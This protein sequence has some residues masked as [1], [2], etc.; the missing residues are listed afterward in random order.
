MAVPDT[1]AHR[2]DVCAVVV[3]Y[4]PDDEFG[5]RVR[6]V[7]AQVAAT[8]IVDNG[9]SAA[10][11]ER[12]RELAASPEVTWIHNSENLGIA[13]ALNQGLQHALGLGFAWALL[14]DQDTLVDDTL[15]ETLRA[16]YAACP[17]PQR[18][19][20]VGARYRDTHDRPDDRR[21]LDAHGETW[22]EV[23]AVITSGTLL[24][25]A[26][27]VAIGPFRDEFFID[28]VDI[29]YCLRARA[30]GYRII[31]TR[32]PL[33]SHTVGAPS[34][35]QM[36]GKSKWTTNHPAERRYYIA[37]NNTVLLREYGSSKGGSWRWKS[38]VRSVRLCK[39][40]A[41]FEQDKL[42]KIAAVAQGWWDGMRG[43]LG[44]RAAAGSRRRTVRS[45]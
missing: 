40:I 6:R 13:R 15:V 21:P 31:E 26:P 39:R 35:H 30:R 41:L 22:Q 7:M 23:E 38:V 20:A 32:H 28:Y 1:S 8:V 37:L 36:M 29:D 33:M 25:L 3:I 18:T 11:A 5:T 10:Q 14:M 16:A 42:A 34:R 43:S 12:L 19:A 24:P 2:S 27:F 44:P 4:H 17:E 9:S 45:P